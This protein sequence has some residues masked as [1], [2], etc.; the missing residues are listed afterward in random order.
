[1]K[2]LFTKGI[3]ETLPQDVLTKKTLDL[4]KTVANLRRDSANLGDRLDL[5]EAKAE[6]RIDKTLHKLLQDA[7]KEKI[8]TLSSQPNQELTGTLRRAVRSK[9]KINSFR[10]LK[11]IE[12]SRAIDYIRA[13]EPPGQTTIRSSFFHR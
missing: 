10:D 13:W 9:F 6:I 8:Q 5:I 7:I 3:V 11:L 1:M 12:F 2:Q 4:E